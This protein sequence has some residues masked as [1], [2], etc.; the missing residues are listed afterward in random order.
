MSRDQVSGIFLFGLG[1]AVF[2]KSWTYP[3]GTLRKPGG[4]LFP[5]IASVLLM[6]LAAFLTVQ[7]FGKKKDREDSA[8]PFFP[9]KEA[10]RRVI[11][12]FA[13][14]LAYRY[15]LPVIGFAAST[16]IFIFFL[17]RF[18]GKY[19]LAVSAGFAVITAVLSYYLFQVWLKVPMPIPLLGI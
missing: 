10:P 4:G 2:L 16:G 1:V 8:A 19:G 12:G 6:G 5:L 9:E 7:A 14:L 13:G 18:L 17:S 11:L 15:L 3:L